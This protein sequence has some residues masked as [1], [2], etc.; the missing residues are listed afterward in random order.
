MKLPDFFLVGAPKCGTTSMYQ[1]LRQHPEIF[2][3]EIKEPNFFANDLEIKTYPEINSVD[4]YSSLYNSSNTE[5]VLG[6][7]SQFHLY[8]KVAAKNIKAFSPQAKIIIMIREPISLMASL[9]GQYQTTNDEDVT[10]FIEVLRLDEERRNGR[11][12]PKNTLFPR[13]MSYKDIATLSPQIERYFKVFSKENIKVV[14]LDD[15]IADTRSVY[16]QTLDFL[17]TSTDFVPVLVPYNTSNKRQE[18]SPLL[19]RQLGIEFSD[20]VR[21]LEILLER[22]LDSWKNF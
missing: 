19:R 11:A 5:K 13:C 21:R 6:D 16:L 20:E 18:V 8:S 9:H 10:S 1:Y 2:L 4:A 3:P 7:A 12:I 17:G 14:L 15:F 22:D